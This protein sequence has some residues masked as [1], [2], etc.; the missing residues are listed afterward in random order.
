MD[1][2]YTELHPR[3]DAEAVLLRLDNKIDCKDF[4]SYVVLTDYFVSDSITRC[5][6]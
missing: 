5:L 1:D 3:S 4:T 2:M 6:S